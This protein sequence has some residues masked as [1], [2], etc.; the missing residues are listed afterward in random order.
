M[1][2]EKKRKRKKRKEKN[3]SDTT[4]VRASA[5][6]PMRRIV[7][8]VDG[9]LCVRT[10]DLAESKARFDSDVHSSSPFTVDQSSC[11]RRK[12]QLD[13]NRPVIAVGHSNGRG[14]LSVP[15]SFLFFQICCVRNPAAA[16]AETVKS[17]VKLVLNGQTMARGK[18]SFPPQMV[19]ERR[20]SPRRL[21][22]ARK[23]G[24]HQWCHQLAH[25]RGGGRD[26]G[27]DRDGPPWT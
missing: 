16:R 5:V 10:A 13:L 20:A 25:H 23:A 19:K 18:S 1:E 3:K 27:W 17:S 9:S 6:V 11:T 14:R 7:C 24:S 22:V 26:D 4:P 15:F 12:Y 2:M 21:R 8:R